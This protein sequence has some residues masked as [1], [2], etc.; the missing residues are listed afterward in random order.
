MCDSVVSEISIDTA[1]LTLPTLSSRTAS[2]RTE[3]IDPPLR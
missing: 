1:M 3:Y 2:P